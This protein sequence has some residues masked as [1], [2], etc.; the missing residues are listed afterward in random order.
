MICPP[1]HALQ[2]SVIQSLNA[3]EVSGIPRLWHSAAWQQR[4]SYL[5]I[6]PYGRAIVPGSLPAGQILKITKDVATTVAELHRH[7]VICC[8]GKAVVKALR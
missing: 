7:E 4:E 6:E 8:Q 1:L 5:I 2:A 3:K